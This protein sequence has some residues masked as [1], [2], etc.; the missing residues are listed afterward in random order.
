[1]KQDNVLL[2]SINGW[3][4]NVKPSIKWLFG[5]ILFGEDGGLILCSYIQKVKCKLRE[6]MIIK[7]IFGKGITCLFS[8]TKSTLIQ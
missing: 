1:M 4:D 5:E 3:Q 6:I 8:S 7:C 2:P